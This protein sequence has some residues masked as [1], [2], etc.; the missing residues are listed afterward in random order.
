MPVTPPPC[1]SS[2][3][4]SFTAP[5]FLVNPLCLLCPCF[6]F[7]HFFLTIVCS[8]SPSLSLD[9]I[10]DC[11]CQLVGWCFLFYFHL[12]LFL[13]GLSG[14]VNSSGCQI[15]LHCLLDGD[16]LS[17]LQWSKPTRL[18]DQDLDPLTSPAV[19]FEFWEIL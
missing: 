4:S 9:L 7:F 3:P 17:S 15:S 13:Q 18:F 14:V 16:I 10:S 19:C 6:P 8:T 11:P 12:A 2:H 5:Y 1:F